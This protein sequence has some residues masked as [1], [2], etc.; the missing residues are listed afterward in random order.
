MYI[1]VIIKNQ[2]FGRSASPEMVLFQL[3]RTD[4]PFQDKLI[5]VR[6]SI[7]AYLWSGYSFGDIYRIN[8]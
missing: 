6:G 1:Y 4:G 2:Y 5:I 8:R 7:S 3:A